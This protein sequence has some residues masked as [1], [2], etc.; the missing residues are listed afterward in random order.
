MLG[1][2][3]ECRK[4]AKHCWALASETENPVLKQSLVEI[5]QRWARLAT[6]LDATHALLKA[7]GTEAPD[8]KTG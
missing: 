5:A 7:W 8:K 1:D 3:K 6:E 2:P 4:H